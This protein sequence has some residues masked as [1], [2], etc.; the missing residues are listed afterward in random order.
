MTREEAIELIV[1]NGTGVQIALERLLHWNET[2][3]LD[4]IAEKLH[5]SLETARFFKNKYRLKAA[6]MRKGF[7]SRRDNCMGKAQRQ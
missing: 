7:Y 1:A 2:L 6:P 3:P 5:I 4:E